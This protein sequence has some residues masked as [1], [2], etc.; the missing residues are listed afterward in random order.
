DNRA[1]MDLFRPR[2]HL[3]IRG[4]L[5]EH[6][7]RTG[8]AEPQKAPKGLKRH[9]KKRIFVLFG[10]FLC[11]LCTFPDSLGKAGHLNSERQP[12][13]RHRSLESQRSEEH[14]SEL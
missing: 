7:N 4:R 8:Q 5:R 10:Y 11:L 6:E 3:N 12:S 14:T 13:A 9:K 1:L 2:G